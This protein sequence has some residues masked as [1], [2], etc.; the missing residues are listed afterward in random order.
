MYTTNI[1]IDGRTVSGTTIDNIGQGVGA[2]S[3]GNHAEAGYYKNGS[4]LNINTINNT[5]SYTE[6]NDMAV[7]K[8]LY[9]GFPNGVANQKANIIIPNTIDSGR[10]WG[11]II[12][13]INSGYSYQNASGSLKVAYALGLNHSG[14]QYT[15]TSMVMV[16]EGA[17]PYHFSLDNQWRWDSTNLNWYLPLAHLLSTGNQVWIQIEAKSIDT[18]FIDSVKNAT[19]GSVYT[20]DTSVFPNRGY[21]YNN[22]FNIKAPNLMVGSYLNKNKTTSRTSTANGITIAGE[23]APTLSLWDTSSSGFHSHLEQVGSDLTLRSSG[24]FSLQVSAGTRA[25]KINSDK[26]IT[27]DSSINVGGNAQIS[28]ALYTDSINRNTTGSAIAVNT[29]LSIRKAGLE[30][31]SA[32]AYSILKNSSNNYY[33]TYIN[34]SD[35]NLYTDYNGVLI[36]AYSPV[37]GWDFRG[38]INGD[39]N[40]IAGSHLI[41]SNKLYLDGGSDTYI[42]ES[43]AN[44][45]DIHNGIHSARFETGRTLFYLPLQP[46][47]DVSMNQWKL[48]KQGGYH[49][50]VVTPVLDPRNVASTAGGPGRWEVARIFADTA[51]WNTTGMTKVRVYERYWYGGAWKE[52]EI[53]FGYT[54]P[55]NQGII[56]QVD[57]GGF[58]SHDNFTVTISGP[59]N[60]N[61]AN[62]QYISIYVRSKSYTQVQAIITSTHNLASGWTNQNYGVAYAGNSTN[63][64]ATEDSFTINEDAQVIKPFYTSGKASRVQ[65]E[66][67]WVVADNNLQVKSNLY[68]NSIQHNT[69]ADLLIGNGT[70]N[71]LIDGGLLTFRSSGDAPRLKFL[72]NS[73]NDNGSIYCHNGNQEIGFLDR[74]SSWAYKHKHNTHHQ[75]RVGNAQTMYNDADEFRVYTNGSQ[76]FSVTTSGISSESRVYASGGNSANWN[77]AYSWGDHSKAGYQ[78]GK[79]DIRLKK[80]IKPIE[81]PLE[82]LSKIRGVD[83]TWKSDNEKGGGVIAQELEKAM[84]EYVHDLN[85]GTGHKT[86]DYNGLIGVLIESVKELKNEIE[87]LKANCNCKG[88]K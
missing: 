60:T 54:N 9:V 3:W 37:V 31:H 51:N 85:N 40:I 87:T 64:D 13:T 48:F 53:N 12:V 42:E 73:G 68:T 45:V 30:I 61:T 24:T 66:N 84:P 20:T 47:S 8:K 70:N 35:N 83:F 74:S 41:T 36:R 17:T 65:F 10:F 79:S 32:N 49:H 25:M 22:S 18:N 44:T 52:F 27:F 88:E 59:Q 7:T 58:G 46:Q 15:N 39:G 71:I 21:E 43:S 56:R 75:W 67:T 77:T 55:L 5:G 76:M 14:A 72:D 16:S 29:G 38:T 63:L 6:L 57:S 19:V 34:D 1:A 2:F 28:G 11:E 69:T 4:A 23:Y 78:T 80:D 86:V 33:R 26:S 50:S 82:K 62:K 81:K